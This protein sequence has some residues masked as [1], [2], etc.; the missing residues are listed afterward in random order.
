M[1]V[2]IMCLDVVKRFLYLPHHSMVEKK[3]QICWRKS[4]GNWKFMFEKKN[5]LSCDL[6][7][8]KYVTQQKKICW[9]FSGQCVVPSA[10]T[11]FVSPHTDAWFLICPQKT[12]WKNCFALSMWIYLHLLKSSFANITL[13]KRSSSHHLSALNDD[14]CDLCFPRI[15][16]GGT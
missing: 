14:R 15:S 8:R 5:L 10:P 4:P 12:V 7:T 3:E 1:Y 13:N 11:P 6:P 2:R 16:C 9:P